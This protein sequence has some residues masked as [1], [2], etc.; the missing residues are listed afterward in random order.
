MKRTEIKIDTTRFRSISGFAR[1]QH[2]VEIL[3]V[4]NRGAG[5]I[6][7]QF[8][9]VH[10]AEFCGRTGFYVGMIASL[11]EDDLKQLEILLEDFIIS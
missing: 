6:P 4:Y 1:Q 9:P 7:P 2:M 5:I 11:K 8:I 3:N 10:K